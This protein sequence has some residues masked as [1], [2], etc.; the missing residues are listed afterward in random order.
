MSFSSAVV[1]QLSGATLSL[2]LAQNSSVITNEFKDKM[3]S[4]YSYKQRHQELRRQLIVL[5]QTDSAAKFA[6]EF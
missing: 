2:K 1:P 6:S 4:M 5:K 3:S